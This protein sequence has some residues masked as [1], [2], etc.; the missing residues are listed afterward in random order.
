MTD[1]AY[2]DGYAV[3]S[4]T[5]REIAV[6]RWDDTP[7]KLTWLPRFLCADGQKLKPGDTFV[8]VVPWLA[9]QEGLDWGYRLR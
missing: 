8:A 3:V 2:L 6:T 5:D 7:R 1:Y 4:D 9:E